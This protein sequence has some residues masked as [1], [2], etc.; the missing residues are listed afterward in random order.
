MSSPREPFVPMLGPALRFPAATSASR[1]GLVAVGGDL[2]VA[3]L[4]LAY[5]SGIF[6]WSAEPITWWSPDP[7]AV[8]N[9]DD[10]HVP[11]SLARLLRRQP[12]R[13]TS[14]R[15]FRHVVEECGRV[16]RGGDST[17]ITP[18]IIEA[19]VDLHRA[20]W[21]HSLEV[22]EG[23]R[24][25]GGIYGVAIGGFFAGESMFHHVSNASK[26]A[27]V[28]LLAGLR[29][30]GFTLFDTQMLTDTTRAIGAVEIPRSEYLERL[31]DAL[32][33]TVSWPAWT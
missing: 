21:A 5:R 14:D 8:F 32:P 28:V 7:R 25:A 13:F 12:F 11:R 26:A 33:R 17:W 24:L 2:S 15:C 6:P 22:W 4:L 20:G 30:A 19:Y 16:P 27:L 18:A 23:D 29:D 31:A 9:L 1:H 10:F 3:R